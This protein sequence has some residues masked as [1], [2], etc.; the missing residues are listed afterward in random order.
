MDA[1]QLSL[2]N[3]GIGDKHGFIFFIFVNFFFNRIKNANQGVGP[4]A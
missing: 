3:L 1:F 2:F 4:S